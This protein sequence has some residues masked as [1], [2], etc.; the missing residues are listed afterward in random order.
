MTCT[1]EP[2]RPAQNLAAVSVDLSTGT[3]VDS[4]R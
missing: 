3:W 1:H 4:T 2:E